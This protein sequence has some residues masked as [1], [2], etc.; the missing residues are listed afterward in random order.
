MIKIDHQ[1]SILEIHTVSENELDQL[2]EVYRQ[3]EDF[4]SLGPVATAS[5]QMVMTDIESA[6]NNQANYCSIHS[7]KQGM[8][9]VV[10]YT[11]GEYLG[12]PEFACLELLMIAKP[13]RA[14]GI[15]HMVVNTVEQEIQKVNPQVS[16][17]YSGV[18]VNN[19]K[20]ILFWQKNGY[21][22]TSGPKEMPDQT[23]VYDL[24]K[25]IVS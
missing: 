22:I 13:F 11:T 8:I 1:G 4:L 20:A 2:M 9:G 12:H 10:E 14:R 6:Q 15:G 21:K 16:I 17:I 19:P 3:C 23:I 5:M 25:R 24:Q 7:D 18:Q